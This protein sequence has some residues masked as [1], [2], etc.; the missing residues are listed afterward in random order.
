MEQCLVGQVHVLNRAAYIDHGVARYGFAAGRFGCDS[1]KECP[2]DGDW[3]AVGSRQAERD[4]LQV[5][6][7]ESTVQ[8][9]LKG[10]QIRLGTGVNNCRHVCV[11]IRGV[12]STAF[13]IL[14]WVSQGNRDVYARVC[15]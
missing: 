15:S 6:L 3:G 8:E 11:G 7:R 5:I 1:T 4:G 14:V 2:L 9:S 13:E 12:F 10:P